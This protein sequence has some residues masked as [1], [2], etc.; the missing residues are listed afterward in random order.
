MAGFTVFNMMDG[1]TY[2]G[3]DPTMDK[4]AHVLNVVSIHTTS[5]LEREVNEFAVE[6]END[7]RDTFLFRKHKQHLSNHIGLSKVKL[8]RQNVVASYVI[9]DYGK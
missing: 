8:N 7:T 4:D 5:E 1:L 2:I 6:Y 9:G 3:Q